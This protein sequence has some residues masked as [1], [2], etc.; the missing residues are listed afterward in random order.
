MTASG[1]VGVVQSGEV[2]G[3]AQT[4]GGTMLWR[5][6]HWSCNA[7]ISLQFPGYGVITNL[8]VGSVWAGWE[9]QTVALKVHTIVVLI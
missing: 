7:L 5:G 2:D 9:L 6:M 4:C 8:P 3:C 1:K